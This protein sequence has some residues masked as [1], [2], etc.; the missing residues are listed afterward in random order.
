MNQICKVL[1][2]TLFIFFLPVLSMADNIE[3]RIK[4]LEQE[5]LLLKDIILNLQKRLDS[6]ENKE[7]GQEADI[8]SQKVEQLKERM[9]ALE[10][11]SE[12]TWLPSMKGEKVR[13]GAKLEL[14]YRDVQ[15]ENN[16]PAGST[17]I[18]YGQFQIDQFELRI[19]A[20]LR[21]DITLFGEVKAKPGE[22][23]LDEAYVTFS[24]LPFNSYI[25]AGLQEKFIKPG[26]RTETYPLSG[27]AF[28]RD[29]DIGI[30]IGGE[31]NPLY[32]R[33]SLSNGLRLK[34]KEIG[35]DDS[36]PIIQDDDKNRDYNDSK[37]FGVGVG[38]KGKFK[39]AHKVD[40]LLF[41]YLSRLSD[42]DIDFL[43]EELPDYESD[44]KKNYIFG[45]NLYYNLRGLRFFSQYIYS[46][47][48]ELEREGWYLQPSYKFK[49]KGVKFVRSI[50]PLYR[51]DRLDTDYPSSLSNFLTWERERHTF[52][53]IAEIEK[54]LKCKVEY[55]LNDEDTG[56]KDIDNDEFLL[57]LQFK[58]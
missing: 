28:W 4:S 23:K 22:T 47:D 18:P 44:R 31:F 21:E 12:E 49:F 25:K 56:G 55:N 58:F 11:Q 37:E 41:S 15:N 33:L 52:A 48:G 24:D 30:E 36:F 20:K 10:K 46:R 40:I 50:E 27:I 7:K 39:K 32:Y 57:Q 2:F 43:K 3:E 17:D 14:E 54:R 26:R 34:E 8:P 13:I 1:L 35:E 53:L 29:E 9:T 51:Y 42:K 6:L 38:Y 19:E 5:N 16:H 45:G